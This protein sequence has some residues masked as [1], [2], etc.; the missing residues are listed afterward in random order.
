M[1]TIDF[2]DGIHNKN[3][4]N[5]FPN[6]S[7]SKQKD[8]KRSKCKKFRIKWLISII[9]WIKTHIKITETDFKMYKIRNKTTTIDL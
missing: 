2:K 3:N 8:W 1:T 4:R 6:V 5:W 9:K 7:N